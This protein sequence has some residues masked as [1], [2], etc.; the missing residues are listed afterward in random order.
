M[1]DRRLRRTLGEQWSWLDRLRTATWW[2]PW[3]LLHDEVA[4]RITGVLSWQPQRWAAC[5]QVLV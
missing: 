3:K 5:W 2:R 4:P 1:L